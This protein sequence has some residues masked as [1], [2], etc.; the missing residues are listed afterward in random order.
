MHKE[1]LIIVDIMVGLAMVLVLLGHQSFGFAPDWYND[2]M[3]QWIYRF[4]MEVFMFLSAFLIR[5]SYQ[6]VNYFRYIG[7]KTRKFLLPFLLVGVAVAAANCSQNGLSGSDAWQYMWQNIKCLVVWPMRSSASF[8]WYIYVLFGFYLVTPL[9]VRMPAWLKR[10]L[11]ILSMGLP[12]LPASGMCCASLFCMHTFFYFLGILCAEGWE[13]L[14]ELKSWLLGLL[15]LPFVV[16]SVLF[17][18]GRETFMEVGD[19]DIVKACL[20]LPFFYLMARIISH[21]D[22][23]TRALSQV[24]KDVF[25]IYLLQMFFIWGFVLVLQHFGLESK[26]PFWLFIIVSASL[27]LMGPIGCAWLAKKSRAFFTERPTKIHLK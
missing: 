25:W 12:L 11:C 23:L 18:T 19:Y 15:S 3:H 4:H 26:I 27:G 21:I 2:V 24:A 10:T 17:L 6:S 13:E 16:W 14:R 1:R 20:S 9:V 5:Y 8:L 22:W 7:R